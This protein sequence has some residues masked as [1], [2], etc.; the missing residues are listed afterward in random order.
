MRLIGLQLVYERPGERDIS[1]GRL[2]GTDR[3][4]AA[5]RRG[6]VGQTRHAHPTE[7]GIDRC[8]LPEVEHSGRKENQSLADEG[9]EKRASERTSRPVDKDGRKRGTSQRER[10]EE[11]I[12]R[13]PRLG[14][15]RTFR[16]LRDDRRAQQGSQGRLRRAGEQGGMGFLPRGRRAGHRE[17]TRHPSPRH[18]THL[19]AGTRTGIRAGRHL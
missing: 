18:A 5:R 9:M 19:D 3:H 2:H 1:V 8:P 16:T 7:L 11:R 15:Q 6:D 12:A 13:H 14:D 17:G 4:E 10:P